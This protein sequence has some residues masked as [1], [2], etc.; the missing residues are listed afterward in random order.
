VPDHIGL[1]IIPGIWLSI[2]GVCLLYKP[3]LKKVSAVLSVTSL[4]RTLFRH[5]VNSVILYVGLLE[6]YSFSCRKED[7]MSV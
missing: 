4:C 3:V 5:P 6:V 2:A 1:A 7:D